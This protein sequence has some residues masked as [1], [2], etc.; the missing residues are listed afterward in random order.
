MEDLKILV[1]MVSG[2]PDMAIWVLGA[3]LF[4]K[5]FIIGSIYGVIRLAINKAHSWLTTPKDSLVNHIDKINDMGIIGSVSDL[6]GQLRRIC[7][8]HLGLENSGS[9]Y[10]HAADIDWLRDAISEKIQRDQEKES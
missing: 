3:Y 10:I 9:G 7:N 6:L 5:V 1:D 2:L 4:Y 8:I